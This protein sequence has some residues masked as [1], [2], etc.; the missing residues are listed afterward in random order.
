MQFP[1]ESIVILLRELA[2]VYANNIV[3]LVNMYISHVF[4]FN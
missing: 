3:D 2:S 1:V 4:V